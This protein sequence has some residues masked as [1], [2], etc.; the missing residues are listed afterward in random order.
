MVP[1]HVPTHPFPEASPDT[2]PTL[3]QTLD[4]IQGRVGTWPGTEFLRPLQKRKTEIKESEVI[5]Q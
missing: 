2:N 5:A 4:L 1:G 3:T